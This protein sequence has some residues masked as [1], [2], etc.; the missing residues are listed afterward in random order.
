VYDGKKDS[1][2]KKKTKGG[3]RRCSRGRPK[4]GARSLGAQDVEN[5]SGGAVSTEQEL[6]KVREGREEVATRVK[7]K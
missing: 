3:E 6:K 1:L 2:S 4:I 5:W 7:R